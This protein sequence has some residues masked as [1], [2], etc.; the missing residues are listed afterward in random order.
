LVAIVIAAITYGM[1]R[2][3]PADGPRPAIKSLVVLPL[4]NLSNDSAQ[5]FFAIGMTDELIGTLAQIRALRVVSRTSAMS[6]KGSNKSLP[7]IARELNVDAVLSGSVQRS[8]ERVRIR[9]QLLHAPSDRY[10]WAR[11]YER[12]L[13]DVLKLQAEVARAIAEEI[14]IQMTPEESA[15]MASAAAVDPAAHEEYLLARYL[16]WKFI[17]EDRLRAVDHF[18]R[19]IE[20]DPDYAAPYAG[21]AHAWWMRGVF[22]PLSMQEV[23][24]PA[25]AAALKAL[26]LDDRLAE[27]YAAQAYVEGMFDWNWAAAERTIQRAVEVDPN[28]MD[29]RYVYALLLMAL[30]RLSEAV[31]QIDYA[32]QLDP[33]SAQ[34][35]S[36]FGRILYRARRFDEAI[37]RLNRAGLLEPRNAGIWGRLGDVYFHMGNHAEALELYK[38]QELLLREEGNDNRIAVVY[39]HMGKTDEARDMLKRLGDRSS[40]VYVALGE[41][42]T[43]FRLLFEDVARRVDWHLYIKADPFYDALHADPRWEDLL[44]RMNLPTDSPA[45]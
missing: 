3:G 25:R 18:K 31:T 27:A 42:D 8:G 33:L 21:L 19:A 2:T 22:G 29:A 35:H 15:R 41:K 11:D 16:L 14:R 37:V 20:I 9:I 28:S 7:T 10:I 45:S 34:V 6:L 26:E 44:R 12:D 30:G 5:D 1:T 17:E 24:E 4:D 39:A 23:A 40:D 32:A 36:T 38:K 43:A 13:T